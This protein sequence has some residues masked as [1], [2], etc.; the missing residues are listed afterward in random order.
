MHKQYGKRPGLSE[1]DTG[2]RRVAPSYGKES[3][4]TFGRKSQ[5][6]M[7]VEQD[8]ERLTSHMLGLDPSVVRYQAQPFV[9]DLVSHAILRTQE[10]RQQ[11]KARHKGKPGP[12]FFTPDFLVQL[13]S[14]IQRVVE[15]KLDGY[16]GDEDYQ[17]K[18]QL[19]KA[20]LWDHGYEF[21]RV[22]VPISPK[23]PLRLNVPL[24]HQAALRKDLRPQPEVY[25]EVEQLALQGASTVAEFCAGLSVSPS[26]A[27]VLLAYGAL[28]MDLHA[29]QIRG[30][31]PAEP[32]YGS[33][34][35]LQMLWS[36]G[37]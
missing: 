19:A 1:V 28:S 36:L 34:D 20:V 23:H 29:H 18:L 30:N 16:L 5:G 33:L 15:V 32:A 14:R 6:L 12:I 21:T 24:L 9:V 8:A 11:A 35:H 37:A 2:A 25:S 7:V 10:Q 4:L 13:C 17:Q 27:P 22:V 26:M 31:A 3:F